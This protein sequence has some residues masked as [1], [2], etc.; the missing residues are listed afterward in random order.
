MNIKQSILENIKIIFFAAIIAGIIRSLLFEPFSSRKIDEGIQT[1]IKVAKN[2]SD[3]FNGKIISNRPTS[4]EGRP[5]DLTTLPLFESGEFF[6][7]L[8]ANIN[9]GETIKNVSTFA[10]DLVSSG[11]DH[12]EIVINPRRGMNQNDLLNH[13][14]HLVSR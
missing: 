12:Y 9:N 5:L 13:F 7:E 11:I 4:K 14:N 3:F 1:A 8:N 10:Q 6:G 2:S